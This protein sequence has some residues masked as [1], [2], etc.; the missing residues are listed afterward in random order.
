M[1][2]GKH[3]IAA[4]VYLFAL[5]LRLIKCDI[6]ELHT[7]LKSVVNYLSVPLHCALCSKINVS[8]LGS[9][10]S[11]HGLKASIHTPRI[12]LTLSIILVEVYYCEHVN[13]ISVL[14]RVKV[15]VFH[16]MCGC[17]VKNVLHKY[18]FSYCFHYLLSFLWVDTTS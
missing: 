17:A 11:W 8:N 13:A 1:L 10:W 12:K 14:T 18:S 15:P 7:G 4:I 6:L 2:E 9:E 16:I 5:G 3:H